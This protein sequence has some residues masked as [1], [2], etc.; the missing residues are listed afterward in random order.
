MKKIFLTLAIIASAFSLMA[1]VTLNMESGNRSTDQSNC[2]AFGA[3][4]YTSAN[5]EV[6]SGSWSAKSNQLSNPSSSACWIKSPWML[7]GS[8]N[9][10]M[11][12]RLLSSNGTTR[13]LSI[14]F[15][16]Y[17][18]NQPYGEGSVMNDSFEYNY[19]PVN[20]SLVNISYTI[21]NSVANSTTPYRVMIS[22]KGTGGNSR[23]AI[24]NIVL[25]GTY[26]SQPSNGCIPTGSGPVDTDND[27]VADADDDYP[28]DASRAF[29]SYYPA[30]DF[31]TLGFEDSWPGRGD[32][33]MNDLVV[34]YRFNTV[35]NANNKIVE[36]KAAIIAKASGASFNNGFGF[37]FAN[38]NISQSDLTCTGSQITRNGATLGSNGLETNQNKPTIIVFDDV[39]DHLNKQGTAT[40]VNTTKGGP[41]VPA[42]TFNILISFSNT[43]YTAAQL[44]IQNFNPFLI[45]NKERGK[46]VHLANYPPTSKAD[47]A[48]FRTSADASNASTG[49]YYKTAIGL[50]WAINVL[51]TF[52]W[53]SERSD[54]VN[55]Y[56][57][58][59]DW[60]ESGGVNYADWYKDLSGYRNTNLIY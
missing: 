57:H 8:G 2:W 16:P 17:D 21:P 59:Q 56:D 29:N 5:N 37:Q 36:V 49:V 28:N 1:Q 13:A 41:N 26:H 7:V 43:N 30:N 11:D 39:F 48:Y 54:I 53:P 4:G 24:D 15:I 58:F 40:G 46:E 55:A 19:N 10:T 22:M 35:T 60:A 52:A 27:G 44:E 33:D 6:I 20:S 23:M 31:G 25:P 34:S 9:I 12:I 14:R 3:V 47:N 38:T 32:Y 18:A 42:D 45:V 50:P 51:G